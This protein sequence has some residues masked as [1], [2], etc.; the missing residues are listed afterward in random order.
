MAHPAL[1]GT[2]ARPIESGIRDRPAM[3]DAPSGVASGGLLRIMRVLGLLEVVQVSRVVPGLDMLTVVRE[4]CP[5]RVLRV[6]RLMRGRKS[7]YFF[8]S[9]P[10]QCLIRLMNLATQY[11]INVSR[12]LGRGK[13]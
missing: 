8:F 9:L 7:S 3:T 6:M 2:R 5:W 10:L 4:M 1:S 13:H 11:N 12:C